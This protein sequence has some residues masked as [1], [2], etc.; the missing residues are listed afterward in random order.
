MSQ[1]PIRKGRTESQVSLVAC[2][3]L[4]AALGVKYLG[5][6]SAS[7]CARLG[8]HVAYHTPN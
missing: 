8:A 5:M 7:L 4:M 3:V 6:A 2:P 1:G